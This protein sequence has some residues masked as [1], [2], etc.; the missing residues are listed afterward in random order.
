MN[1][2]LQPCIALFPQFLA[3]ASQFLASRVNI[4]P[5]PSVDSDSI[6]FRRLSPLHLEIIEFFLIDPLSYHLTLTHRFRPQRKWTLRSTYYCL[7][8][9]SCG[10]QSSGGWPMMFL[11]CFHFRDGLYIQNL[12]L[13]IPLFIK[14]TVAKVPQWM[15]S[16]SGVGS[17]FEFV[18]FR[19]YDPFSIGSLC[20]TRMQGW[21]M[22]RYGFVFDI[23]QMGWFNHQLAICVC[24]FYHLFGHPGGWEKT[25]CKAW[26][27]RGGMP[28]NAEGPGGKV[29]IDGW[30][31]WWW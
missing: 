4:L 13:M 19:W 27:R 2:G 28:W 21:E 1:P 24:G 22:I 29:Q 18:V 14:S 3:R 9:P 31:P 25:W 20:A 11:H 26:G 15:L 12:R 6:R 8:V 17:G 10:R 5:C 23:F 7:F 16:T 30:S